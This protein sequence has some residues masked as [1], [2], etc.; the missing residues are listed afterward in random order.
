VPGGCTIS[1]P[2]AHSRALR[3]L[4][5]CGRSRS[6]PFCDNSHEEEGWTCASSSTWARIGFCASERYHNLALKLASHHQGALCWPGEPFPVVDRLVTIV[7]G[8]DLEL[9]LAVHREV[10]A[11]TRTVISLGIPANLLQGIFA[12]CQVVD[13]GTIDIFE[14]FQ[15][16]AALVNGG[17]GPA[18]ALSSLTMHTGFISHAVHDEPLLMP[19]VDYLRRHFPVNLFVCADSIQPGTNWQDMIL[20]ALREQQVFMA[21][22]SEASRSSHFCSFEIGV[23]HGLHKPIRLLS[24]DGSPPPAFVQHIQVVDL[25]RLCRQKPWLDL[26]DI[27][28]FELLKG[29]GDQG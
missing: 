18:A 5:A 10:Q 8:T 3:K 16:I 9:P 7:D 11:R 22:L 4:C 26:Q 20:T 27:L 19:V 14:A 17:L 13:L 28:V 24:L 29:L 1:L 6:F 12:G 23:A 21:L 25:P 15:R 2:S